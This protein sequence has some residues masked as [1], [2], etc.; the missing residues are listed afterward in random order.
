MNFYCF[1]HQEHKDIHKNIY[2]H[3]YAF[4]KQAELFFCYIVLFSGHNCLAQ[5]F[6][7]MVLCVKSTLDGKLN[8]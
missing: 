5:F 1:Q 2:Q 6:K 8:K 4:T 7:S 3:L